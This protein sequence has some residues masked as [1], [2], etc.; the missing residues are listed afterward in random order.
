MFSAEAD[1]YDVVVHS[2]AEV[3][4]CSLQKMM[5]MM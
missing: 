5:D 2:R 3:G 4:V 1:G